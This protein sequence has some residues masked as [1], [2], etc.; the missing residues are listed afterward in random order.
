M[1]NG[2]LEL[3]VIHHA[4]LLHAMDAAKWTGLFNSTTQTL[5]SARPLQSL[6]KVLRCKAM[7]RVAR[8]VVQ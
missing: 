4:R 8:T 1:R 6:T 3:H 2:L 7:Q 5:L